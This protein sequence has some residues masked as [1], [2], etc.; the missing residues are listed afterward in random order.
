M[1]R[2]TIDTI[3]LYFNTLI[4]TLYILSNYS[5]NKSNTSNVIFNEK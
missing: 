2:L 5:L 4:F 1:N 3:S